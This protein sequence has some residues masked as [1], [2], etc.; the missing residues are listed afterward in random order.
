MIYLDEIQRYKYTTF[1]SK[2]GNTVAAYTS[3][4]GRVLLSQMTY[5]EFEETIMRQPLTP[6]TPKTVT[7][8]S[9]L[10]N[11]LREVSVQGY[12]FD[13]EEFEMGICCIAA[14]IRDLS[15]SVVAAFGI[16]A[17]SVRLNKD[18]LLK[19]LPSILDTS[20]AISSDLGYQQPLRQERRK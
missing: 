12:A 20:Y 6:R 1:G 13:D 5:Q 8:P 3:A 19:Y 14:P 9:I 7:D 17:P 2:L 16:S 11:I 10:W 4:M 18:T 15:G